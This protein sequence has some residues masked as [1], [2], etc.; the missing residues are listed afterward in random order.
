MTLPTRLPWLKFYVADEMDRMSGMS[1]PEIGIYFKAVCRQW[2]DGDLPSEPPQL[3]RALRI[4]LK[5]LERYGGA[6]VDEFF[7]VNA[8]GRRTNPQLALAR[9]E[10]EERSEG[11]RRAAQARWGRDVGDDASGDTDAMR[12]HSVRNAIRG[13]ENKNRAEETETKEERQCAADDS[14]RLIASIDERARASW[15]QDIQAM[16]IGMPGHHHLAPDEL[17]RVCRD[18]LGRDRARWPDTTLRGFRAFVKD[19]VRTRDRGTDASGLTEAEW[20]LAREL[21]RI[22][23]QGPDSQGVISRLGADG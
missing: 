5:E 9:T 10:A 4:P 2:I 20:A 15:V 21:A 7:P 23:E 17:N 8:A 11:G 16:R 18:Y 19:H 12:L 1:L 6:V 22:A 13:E 14:E 3:A